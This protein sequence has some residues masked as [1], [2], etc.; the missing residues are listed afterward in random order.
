LVSE[1]AIILLS[2]GRRIWSYYDTTW[3]T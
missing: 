1:K 3:Y 2:S